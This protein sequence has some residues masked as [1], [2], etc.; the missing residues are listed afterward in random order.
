[1]PI[2]QED[3]WMLLKSYFKEIGLVRQHLDSLIP[4]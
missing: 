4:F 3:A 2:K 1:M